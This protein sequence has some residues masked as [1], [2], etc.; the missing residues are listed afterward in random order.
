MHNSVERAGKQSF[1]CLRPKS[2]HSIC[3][4]DEQKAEQDCGSK[5]C[6]ISHHAVGNGRAFALVP[7]CPTKCH[8]T[9][10]AAASFGQGD[11]PRAAFCSASRKSR[12]RSED[13][14]T[15]LRGS[16][17]RTTHCGLLL[18]HRNLAEAVEKP[19]K[20]DLLQPIGVRLALTSLR[21]HALSHEL[22]NH[23]LAP[24]SGLLGCHS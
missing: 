18:L 6:Q 17:S 11:C 24:R 16:A 7:Q 12:I 21:K 1:K 19:P 3:R 23:C 15:G 8:L 9:P 22:A 14:R 20:S 2:V 5:W 13:F 10:R 4:L